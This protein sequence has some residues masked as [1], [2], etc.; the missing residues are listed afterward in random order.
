MPAAHI[1][2]VLPA[3]PLAALQHHAGSHQEHRH[4]AGEINHIAAV[5]HATAYRAVVIAHAQLADRQLSVAQETHP[6]DGLES[7]MHKCTHQCS[8][9]EG[10]NLVV[11]QRAGKHADGH[12]RSPQQQQAQIRTHHSTG[13]HI[14]HRVAQCHNTEIAHYRRQQRDS[15]QHH[16]GKEL[17]PYQGH[18]AQRLGKQQLHCTVALFLGQHTHGDG[19]D[20]EQI[21][22]RA[23]EEQPVHACIP[24]VENIEIR[25]KHP[26]HQSCKHKKHHNGQIPCKGREETGKLFFKQ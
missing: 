6:A 18:L 15:H 10:H 2:L 13:V 3:M 16:T 21:E 17:G 22:E 1:L 5:H 4:D 20:K 11:R 7:E 12:K 19:R 26:Q 24:I 25:L 23:Y 9:D 8:Q 14:A